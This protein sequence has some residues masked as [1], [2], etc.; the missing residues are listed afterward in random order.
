MESNLNQEILELIVGSLE[1]IFGVYDTNFVDNTSIVVAEYEALWQTYLDYM[2]S[3]EGIDA[4]NALTCSFWNYHQV[5]WS[6]QI[7]VES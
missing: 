3:N 7:L 4:I 1:M 6:Y 2:G 5:S